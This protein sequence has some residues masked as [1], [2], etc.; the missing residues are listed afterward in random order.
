MVVIS[1]TVQDVAVFNSTGLKWVMRRKG[2]IAYSVVTH[3]Y[4]FSILN[5]T[6]NL[7]DRENIL[8]LWHF[9]KVRF[10][11]PLCAYKRTKGAA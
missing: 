4:K 10:V 6:L 5:G 7:K 3:F 8:P 1:K 9:L 2:N 11:R